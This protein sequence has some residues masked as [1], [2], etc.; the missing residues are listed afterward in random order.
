MPKAN[1]AVPSIALNGMA[2]EKEEDPA[3]AQGPQHSSM[4]MTIR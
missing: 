4:R 1:A 2:D 3:A